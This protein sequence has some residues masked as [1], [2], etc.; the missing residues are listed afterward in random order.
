[1]STVLWA[2]NHDNVVGLKM[3]QE[4]SAP[5]FNDIAYKA[6]DGLL[7]IW[8]PWES[9]MLDGFKRLI[10]VGRPWVEWV[11]YRMSRAEMT[12][13]L[14]TFGSYATIHTLD[15]SSNTYKNFNAIFHRP[16]LIDQANWDVN[17]WD[18]VHLVFKDLEEIT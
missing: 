17:Y 10:P 4:F 2:N 14:T 1:M 7:T 11:I 9:T 18:N 12:Y 15:K 5:L 3:F 16:D 13:I 8:H 6:T